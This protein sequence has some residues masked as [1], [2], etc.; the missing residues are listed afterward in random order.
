MSPNTVARCSLDIEEVMNVLNDLRNRSTLFPLNI[1]L[2][3]LRETFFIAFQ[4]GITNWSKYITYKI[5]GY[6]KSGMFLSAKVY[7]L[8]ISYSKRT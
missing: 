6:K 7:L 2:W 1:L 8:L 5:Y 3:N 4:D